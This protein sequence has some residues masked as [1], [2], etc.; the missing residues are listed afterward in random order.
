MGSLKLF[1]G[2]IVD[3]EILK[4]QDAIVNPTN[5]RMVAGAGVSGAIFRKAGIDKL[6]RYTQANFKT[7]MIVGEVRVVDGFDLGMDI[8]FIQGPVAYEYDDPLPV[9]LDTYKHLLNKIESYGYK[10]VVMPSLGTG[11]YGYEHEDVAKMVMNL[12]I[13]FVKDKDINIKY[14]LYDKETMWI[15]KSYL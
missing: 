9:L 10:N 15:Y 4:G 2:D 1:G 7:E 5:P 12:I 3:D 11:T 8:I 6:E 13:N 14:V